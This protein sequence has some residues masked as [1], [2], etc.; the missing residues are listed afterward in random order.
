MVTGLPDIYAWIKL[1]HEL[2]GKAFPSGTNVDSENGNTIV[3][4]VLANDGDK[5]TGDFFVVASLKKDG[6]ALPPP[7]PAQLIQLQ[8]KQ[9]WKHEHVVKPPLGGTAKY[10]ARLSS[11]VVQDVDEEDETN[12]IAKANFTFLD[13]PD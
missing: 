11:D 12:N 10:E 2:S 4:Y 8:P 7:V 1:L 3:R 6:V 5:P 13:I 9:I